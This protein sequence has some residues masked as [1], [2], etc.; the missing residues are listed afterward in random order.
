[1][2]GHGGAGGDVDAFDLGDTGGMDMGMGGVEDFGG[3]FEAELDLNLNEDGVAPDMQQQAC[4]DKT[5]QDETNRL[6]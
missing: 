2:D 3:G 5:R 4:A 6:L 1:M